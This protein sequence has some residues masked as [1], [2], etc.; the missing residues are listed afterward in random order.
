MQGSTISGTVD[1][2]Q[3]GSVTNTAYQTGQAGLGVVGYQTDQFDNLSI[4]PGT[5]TGTGPSGPVTS[6][7]AGKC[8]DDYGGSITNG[9]KADLYDCNNTVAQNWTL[10]NGTLQ[11]QGACLDVVGSGSTASGTL[12][13]IWSCNGGS[14]QQWSAQ[15]GELVNPASGKCLDDPGFNTTNGTQL[16]IWGCNGGA[17]QLWT[18]PS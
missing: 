12:V 18:L 13:D 7:M 6:G 9:T 1:G 11:I 15:N 17:N 3:V 10:A 14:N 16:E 2:K 5:G 4:T 8:L